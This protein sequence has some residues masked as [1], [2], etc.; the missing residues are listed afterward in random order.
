MTT[1][2]LQPKIYYYT[3]GPSEPLARI[4]SGDTVI[5]ETRDAMGNDARRDPM[6]PAMKQRVPGAT[7]RESNPCIGHCTWR[8]LR[9]AICSPSIFAASISTAALPSANR[10]AVSDR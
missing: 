5:A 9:R 6:P 3:F 1:H 10:A 7:L 8:A 2:H 4:K